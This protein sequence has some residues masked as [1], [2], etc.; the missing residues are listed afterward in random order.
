MCKLLE[1][2]RA[3]RPAS[4]AQGDDITMIIIDVL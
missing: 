4:M 2:I 1:E 3:W